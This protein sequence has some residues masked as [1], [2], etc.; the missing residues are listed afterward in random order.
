MLEEESLLREWY[1]PHNERLFR[2]LGRD[3]GWSSTTRADGT[4][5][6]G[7][8]YLDTP[9]QGLA[10]TSMSSVQ[11]APPSDSDSRINGLVTSADA[12]VVAEPSVDHGVYQDVNGSCISLEDANEATDVNNTTVIARQCRPQAHDIP[13]SGAFVEAKGDVMPDREVDTNPGMDVR[14]SS[15]WDGGESSAS[16]SDSFDCLGL[17]VRGMATYL[18]SYVHSCTAS[19]VG[20]W[21]DRG[22]DVLRYF[23]HST[24]SKVVIA[25]IVSRVSMYK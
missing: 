4:A 22:R 5:A 1:R 9:V 18:G 7:H 10:A 2:L 20:C 16:L 15:V 3:L 13:C 14:N 23:I 8:R 6:S 11:A 24:E 17:W 12:C 25:R 19:V 21:R